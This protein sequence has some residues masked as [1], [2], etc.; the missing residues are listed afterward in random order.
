MHDYAVDSN[1]R[2][3]VP[4]YL[5]IISILLMEGVVQPALD[6]FKVSVP[7]WVNGISVFG[8]YALFLFIFDR[9]I[10]KW[11]FLG[12]IN[13]VKTPNINGS[14]SGT[15]L[16]SY[17]NFT[18]PIVIDVDIIQTWTKIS[19]VLRTETS[20]SRST[21]AS[22]MTNKEPNVLSYQYLNVPK[23]NAAPTMHMHTGTA[24]IDIEN[25]C[26]SLV[27]G[28][29]SSRDRQTR[30]QFTLKKTASTER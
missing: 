9:H 22:I 17:D 4:L 18:K 11:Q 8:F 29:Y 27:G 1:E 3:R 2:L 19:I 26:K 7:W 10:W 25:D 15:L 16:S 5:A 14:Y 12:R 24:V 23:Q 6:L 21:V 20:S 13:V 30:G 28:F